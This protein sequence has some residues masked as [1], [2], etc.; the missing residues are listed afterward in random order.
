MV[1]ICYDSDIISYDRIT[2]ELSNAPLH[3][4]QDASGI[5]K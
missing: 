5:Y 2:P 1:V 4:K 3:M